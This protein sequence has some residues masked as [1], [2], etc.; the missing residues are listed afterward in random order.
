MATKRTVQVTNARIVPAETI[1]P[2]RCK[3]EDMVLLADLVSV[4]PVLTH[5]SQGEPVRTSLIVEQRLSKRQVETLNTIYE[6]VE[7]F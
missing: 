6:I 3:P 2:G 7:V 4:H 5:L 1:W